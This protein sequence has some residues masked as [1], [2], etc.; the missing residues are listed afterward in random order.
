MSCE[1]FIERLH[2]YVPEK[3]ITFVPNWP[4]MKYSPNHNRRLSGKFNFTF[5]GNIGKVQ[6]LDNIVRGFSKFTQKGYSEVYLNI[7]G[8]G[9]YLT[10]LQELV[11]KENICNVNFLGRKPLSEMS[12]YYA[13]SDVLII[14]LKDTPL[15][16][17]MIPS[18]FQAYL[19][20]HKPIY[21]IFKGEIK[22]IVEEYGLGIVAHPSN[23]EEI[24]V[25]LEAFLNLSDI[26]MKSISEN[27]LRL[28]NSVFNRE[29]IIEQINSIYWRS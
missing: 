26:Q 21:A 9:S 6:N 3:D 20:T 4:L 24:A 14:S 28:L 1:G 12:D 13:A 25:G 18:K 27:S 17:I 5:A 16:E 19:A 29:K 10:E 23:I 8:D 7:I 15:Y 2:N 11:K 22:K